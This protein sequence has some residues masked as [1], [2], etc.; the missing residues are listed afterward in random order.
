MI[1][2][3]CSSCGAKFQIPD[4]AAGKMIRCRRCDT[5]TPVPVL[6]ESPEDFATEPDWF[7]VEEPPRPPRSRSRRRKQKTETSPTPRPDTPAGSSGANLTFRLQGFLIAVAGIAVIGLAF[8]A[9]YL[10]SDRNDEPGISADDSVA[11]T[12]SEQQAAPV[13][14]PPI[15]VVPSVTPKLSQPRQ[16]KQPN[17]TEP[18]TSQSEKPDQSSV[19]RPAPVSP[20]NGGSS[21]ENPGTSR[22]TAAAPRV[23]AFDPTT[24]AAFEPL[25]LD[26]PATSMALTEDRRF[27]VISH[28]AAH[29]VSVFDIEE[30]R[31]TTTISTESPRS[32]LCR[33][34]QIF[35]ANYGAG[36]ISVFSMS[37]GWKQTNELMVGKK[38]IVHMS[39]A[40]AENFASELLVTCHVPDSRNYAGT[41]YLVDA[42]RDRHKTINGHALASISYDGRLAVTQGSFN[43]SPGG[44]MGFFTFRSFV[45]GKPERLYA[46]GISQ[47][48]YTYQLYPGSLWFGDNQVFGGNPL[49]T[50]KGDLGGILV[51]DVSQKLAYAIDQDLLRT[52]RVDASMTEMDWKPR[53]VV[54]P[55]SSQE[56]S[57]IS[58][59]VYRRREYMLDHPIGVTRNDVL[60]LFIQ[61]LKNGAILHARTAAFQVVPAPRS[62]ASLRNALLD[63]AVGGESTEGRN[64]TPNMLEAPARGNGEPSF[65]PSAG[66]T[67]GSTSRFL[68]GWPEFI[69]AGKQFEFE[70]PSDG[71]VSVEVVEESSPL[72]I[73]AGNRLF[74]LPE[75]ADVGVHEFKLRVTEGGVSHFARPAVEVISRE[76]ANEVDNDLSRLNQFERRELR[77]DAVTLSRGRGADESLVLQ[78]DELTVIG[79]SLKDARTRTLPRRYK[80]IGRRRGD[81]IAVSQNPPALD[82]LDAR[83]LRVKKQV[84]LSA[85]T[86]RI[87]EVTDLTAHPKKNV[88]CLCVRSSVELPRFRVMFI[89]E[90]SGQIE[91]M[92]IIGNWAEFSDGGRF[93]F[94]GYSDTYR[95]GT[96]FH[97]NP[98][99]RLIATPSYGGIDM[100]LTWDLSGRR[101]RLVDIVEEAGGNGQ[102]ICLSAAEDRIVFLSH[103]GS[104]LHSGNLL[105]YSVRDLGK[106]SVAYQ[107]KG[108]T[109]TKRGAFHPVL[110][111][112][113]SVD[114]DSITAFHADT[115]EREPHRLMATSR[116]V[117]GDPVSDI[118]FTQSG[119]SLI[120]VRTDPASGPYLQ[121]IGLRTKTAERAAARRRKPVLPDVPE[122]KPVPRRDLT[123]LRNRA[124][125]RDMT[126]EDIGK[127]FMKSVVVVLTPDGSGTGFVVGT[128]GYIVTCEHVVDGRAEAQVMYPDPANPDKFFTCKAT[129]LHADPDLDAALL[130]IEPDAPMETVRFRSDNDIP[131]GSAVTVIGNPGAGAGILDYTMTTGIVSNASR[132]INGVETIQ[133]SAAVNPGN[134]G[135]PL[136]DRYGNVAGLVASKARIEGAS[137]A[138]NIKL[139]REFLHRV[140]E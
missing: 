28:Q 7:D 116:G 122:F 62:N 88:T 23:P 53:R 101:P 51:G 109:G 95:A 33:G 134:S 9:G 118:L 61:D 93:L 46:G 43:L 137:F 139:V 18:L 70:I 63:P 110:P 69:V 125:S 76:L 38:H 129:V 45:E 52:H 77:N 66:S 83:T 64:E 60:H 27:L 98:D 36:T 108:V 24:H 120:L 16:Q 117:S 81:Y 127:A 114:D 21:V 47:T 85:A 8:A 99:W 128:K 29:T 112:F 65:V 25:L 54:L 40:Q 74:W 26:E 1:P 103:T 5:V 37:D 32:I 89:D 131:T 59:R 75:S 34:D 12:S 56:F 68:A 91:S 58:Q 30:G 2:V 78:G 133:I 130:K 73:E 42:I 35:V 14:D 55:K 102:G 11:D 10:M 41:I 94:T 111:L 106:D 67:A 39:A 22:Q 136:F 13:V 3:E 15:A 92:P 44:G 126:P 138:V 140:S 135:G 97:I 104:P 17:S 96:N 84:D 123:S 119:E 87:L 72:K 79:R 105:G 86:D 49:R 121:E 6:N 57:R 19:A 31:V 48:P 50:V 115:G 82:V 80:L 20:T 132:N 90:D 107:T 100:L 71:D 113:V 124:S 4:A